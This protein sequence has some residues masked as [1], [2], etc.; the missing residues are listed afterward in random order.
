MSN[1]RFF[2]P[3]RSEKVLST[4]SVKDQEVKSVSAFSITDPSVCPKCDSATVESKLLSGESVRFCTNC[5]VSMA[6][7]E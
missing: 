5:R 4:S 6:L 2:N 3:L 1:E 7:P